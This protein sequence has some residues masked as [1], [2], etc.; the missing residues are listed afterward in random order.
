MRWKEYKMVR[1][2]NHCLSVVDLYKPYQLKQA[3]AYGKSAR[4]KKVLFGTCDTCDLF[5][6]ENIAG[7]PTD[8]DGLKQP[9][10]RDGCKGTIAQAHIDVA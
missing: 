3:I 9:C 4:L 2:D 7:L 10:Y 8:V 6:A 5:F 1:L